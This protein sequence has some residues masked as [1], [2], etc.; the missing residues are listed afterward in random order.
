M[1]IRGK[2]CILK[3]KLLLLLRH[4]VLKY[5]RYRFYND[6]YAKA[7]NTYRYILHAIF[8]MESIK[9][10]P[11]SNMSEHEKMAN[12]I[13][14]QALGFYDDTEKKLSADEILIL[15]NIPEEKYR[16]LVSDFHNLW[17]FRTKKHALPHL[18]GCW[19]N[20]PQSQSQKLELDKQKAL[21]MSDTV[22]KLRKQYKK[23]MKQLIKEK[24]D[25]QS[26]NIIGK[27]EISGQQLTSFLAFLTAMFFVS[28]FVHIK[29]VFWNYYINVGDFFTINDYV[30]VSIESISW[31][32]I[33]SFMSLASI[34][35]SSVKAIKQSVIED[36]YEKSD[37]LVTFENIMRK[38]I[39]VSIV[40]LPIVVSLKLKDITPQSIYHSAI[41]LFYIS[42]FRLPIWRYIKNYKQV[43]FYIFIVLAMFINLLYTSFNEAYRLEKNPKNEKYDVIF[44]NEADTLKNQTLIMLN[45]NY[46]F[47]IEND[48]QEVIIIDKNQIKSVKAT[49]NSSILKFLTIN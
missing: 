10:F 46:A 23:E 35:Y 38:I 16:N 28:G 22:K 42:F 36:E 2:Y 48:T 49:K 7:G 41:I 17:R 26:Y 18:E 11:T 15:K 1:S 24:L 4:A 45:S 6:K 47:F 5:Q 40:I 12:R 33:I 44:K 9:L 29:L 21:K 14:N 8:C 3:L 27:V 31:L 34:I 25:D 13:K 19:S 30:S 32:L 20:S 37:K 39:V 43:S